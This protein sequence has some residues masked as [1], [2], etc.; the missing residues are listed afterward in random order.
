VVERAHGKAYYPSLDTANGTEPNRKRDANGC[1]TRLVER[2]AIPGVIDGS[3][4]LYNGSVVPV[5]RP[6]MRGTRSW[7]M[8]SLVES[9]MGGTTENA[10]IQNL[11]RLA[12]RFFEEAR[13]RGLSPEER[14]LNFVATQT[15]GSLQTLRDKFGANVAWELDSISIKRSPTCRDDSDCHD[16]ETAFYDP[17]NVLRSKVVIARTVDVSD[18]VPVLLGD[19]REYRRR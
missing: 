10:E 14:A 3:V 6:D 4:R 17:D 11:Q 19:D 7:N 15:F 9:R 1:P 16:V 2:V 13:N 8:A 12:Q 18:K 5:I